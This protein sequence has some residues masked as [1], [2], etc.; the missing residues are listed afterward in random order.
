MVSTGVSSPWIA[1]TAAH[2]ADQ[3]AATR[4]ADAYTPAPQHADPPTSSIIQTAAGLFSLA[5]IAVPGMAMAQG[6]GSAADGGTSIS[7]AIRN[8]TDDSHD[9]T[10]DVGSGSAL[11][12]HDHSTSSMPPRQEADATHNAAAAKAGVPDAVATPKASDPPAAGDEVPWYDSIE[13][14]SK[15][16]NDGFRTGL[17]RYT[18]Q[19][20]GILNAN[21]L[22]RYHARGE[23]GGYHWTF[24]PLNFKLEPYITLRANEIAAG[25]RGEM[26]M[27]RWGM[28]NEHHF[29]EWT[30]TQG[31][32]GDIYAREEIRKGESIRLNGLHPEDVNAHFAGPRV[33]L[34][35][36]WK[37]A[38]GHDWKLS[39]DVSVGASEDF[40]TGTPIAYARSIQRAENAKITQPW[41]GQGSHLRL[42]TE[43][44]IQ[45]NLHDGNT[46]PY[47]RAFG[48]VTKPIPIHFRGKTHSVEVEAGLQA[49]GHREEP[50]KVAPQVRARVHW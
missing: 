6:G 41:F 14:R 30:R 46:S 4:I 18:D 1:A 19:A 16:I 26:S 25:A 44:G 39:A 49:E 7:R 13:Q 2:G 29:G 50:F 35:Q 8:L 24:D 11:S 48:G 38:D 43:E 36:Q 17:N 45:E 10:E 21:P 42:E 34:F 27:L 28:Q 12:A 33:E 9:G 20:N 37:L 3:G 47:Y 23:L 15:D 5:F 31:V 40:L 22:S 32:R